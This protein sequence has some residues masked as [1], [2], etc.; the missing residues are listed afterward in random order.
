M[1]EAMHGEKRLRNGML[2]G[3]LATKDDSARCVYIRMFEVSVFEGFE[4]FGRFMRI[5][6]EYIGVSGC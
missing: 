5:L 6:S 3:E 4:V 2:A 1:Y